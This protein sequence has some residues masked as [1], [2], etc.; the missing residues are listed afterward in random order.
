MCSSS[1]EPMPSTM[2]SPKQFCQR[3][4]TSGASGSAALTHM[5]TELRSCSNASGRFTIAPYNVGTLKNSV[6]RCSAAV[7]S[8]PFGSGR[9]G[10][11]T[12]VAPTQYGKVRLLPSPYAW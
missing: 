10:R 4:S 7:S 11:S 9:P 8:S 6:G 5:R 12:V 3:R 2:S 1:V